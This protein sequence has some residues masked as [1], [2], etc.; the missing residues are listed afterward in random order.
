[1]WPNVEYGRQF[2]SGYGQQK[3]TNLDVFTALNE[4]Y[5][6]VVENLRVWKN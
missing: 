2:W 1:M 4:K 3:I 6:D 5:W